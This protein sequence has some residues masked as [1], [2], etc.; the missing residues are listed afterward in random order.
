MGT[1]QQLSHMAR[2]KRDT[3]AVKAVLRIYCMTSPISALP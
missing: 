1:C 3:D 2:L